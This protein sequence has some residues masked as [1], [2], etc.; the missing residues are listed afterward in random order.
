MATPTNRTSPARRQQVPDHWIVT[1][2][3]HDGAIVERPVGGTWEYALT[4]ARLL[5]PRAVVVC[6]DRVS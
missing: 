2:R 5:D 3:L 1:Y 6:I 4:S